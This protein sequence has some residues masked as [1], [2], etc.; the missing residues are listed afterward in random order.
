KCI[1]GPSTVLLR[2]DIYTAAG[3]FREDLPVAEDYELWLH[4]TARYAAGYIDQP[5]IEKRAGHGEQLSEKWGAI[6]YFRLR[7]LLDFLGYHTAMPAPPGL[8]VL[9]PDQTRSITGASRLPVDL[10]QQ[11]EAELERKLRVFAKGAAKRGYTDITAW[12]D[13]QGWKQPDQG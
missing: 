8:P 12:C 13:R 1:I 6:E 4:I 9:H 11:A 2:R 3:G 10:L 5:L 7:A